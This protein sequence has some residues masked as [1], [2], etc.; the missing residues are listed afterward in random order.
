ML[1]RHKQMAVG[2]FDAS[3]TELLPLDLSTPVSNLLLTS[4]QSL[5]SPVQA[6]LYFL[7]ELT[8]APAKASTDS[9]YRAA[10]QSTKRRRRNAASPSSPAIVSGD[11]P[12]RELQSQL[13]AADGRQCG[14]L[15]ALLRS[16]ALLFKLVS[17]LDH[18]TAPD[19]NRI[20]KVKT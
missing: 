17:L 1:T 11:Q 19:T 10:S 15:V 20:K 8:S 7:H 14:R 4:V 16:M 2:Y 13:P 18:V 3:P 5:K 12:A 9:V 6:V